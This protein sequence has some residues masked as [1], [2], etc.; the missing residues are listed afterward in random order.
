LS[1]LFA[2][3]GLALTTRAAATQPR[4]HR[5]RGGSRTPRFLSVLRPGLIASALQQ[6]LAKIGITA[7]PLITQ[8]AHSVGL[9]RK[10]ACSR[11][12]ARRTIVT[13]YLMTL[14]QGGAIYR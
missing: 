2:G 12:R 6:H 3:H 4:L 14:A 1:Q 10:I 5:S 13:A 8:S 7:G 11:S 9:G